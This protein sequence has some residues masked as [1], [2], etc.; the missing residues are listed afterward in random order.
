VAG[1]LAFAPP[2]FSF[3]T[4]TDLNCDA[5]LR[6]ESNP[7]FVAL[8]DKR[9]KHLFMPRSDLRWRATALYFRKAPLGADF[10]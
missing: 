4:K 7:W 9:P 3:R 6:N 8:P 2:L 10:R 1:R 5:V